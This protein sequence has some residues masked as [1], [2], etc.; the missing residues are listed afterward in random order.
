MAKVVSHTV[1]ML[2]TFGCRCNRCLWDIRLK[3][4]RLPEFNMLFQP[5]LTKFFKNEL[6]SCLPKVDHMIKSCK[7]LFFGER[8]A[9]FEG[10]I[11]LSFKR[12]S[13][14]SNTR[15]HTELKI[16][17]RF[18][19]NHLHYNYIDWLNFSIRAQILFNFSWRE[20]AIISR[21]A[22]ANW[23]KEGK[24]KWCLLFVLFYSFQ[25]P[26]SKSRVS[27]HEIF[28]KWVFFFLN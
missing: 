12:N 3:I 22:G 24:V 9:S 7:S 18:D 27:V 11:K 2:P 4:L 25:S 26:F 10:H 13:K 21:P 14:N 15:N 23:G 1:Q 5:V 17:V 6:F 8:K 28:R 20:H 19:K 16:D